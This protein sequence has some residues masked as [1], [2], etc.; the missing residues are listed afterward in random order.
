MFWRS[1][2]GVAAATAALAVSSAFADDPFQT[3]HDKALYGI[4]RVDGGLIRYDFA[5]GEGIV[6]GKVRSGGRDLTGIEAAAYIPGFQNIF[7]FWHDAATNTAKLA[8]VDTESGK[9]VITHDLE[10]G[11]IWGAT[12]AQQQGVW[13]VYALQHEKVTPP[14]TISGLLNINPNNS[15]HNEFTITTGGGVTYTR[16]HL[17]SSTQTQSD[18]T[19]YRGKATYIRVKPKGNGNQNSLVIDGERFVMQNSNTY[20]LNGDM[21]VRVYNDHVKN[22]KAMGHW[23]LEITGGTAQWE[24]NSKAEFPNRL[25]K[26]DHQTGV[27]TELFTVDHKYTGLATHDGVVFWATIGDELWKLDAAAE[28]ETFVGTMAESEVQALEMGGETLTGFELVY[29]RLTAPN[30]ET[31]ERLARPVHL[32]DVRNLG[33]IVYVD[34]VADPFVLAD[35]FD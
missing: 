1:R 4:D 9:A 15:S 11:K 31:A 8:Y 25:V 23:W 17:H 22:G 24:E 26:I 27:V 29:H 2:F 10:G 6:V 18:G 30:P 32:G 35:A 3:L 33:T 13:S 20:I 14:F 5:S 19:F 21:D 16:D 7:A 28:T 34:V 12:A